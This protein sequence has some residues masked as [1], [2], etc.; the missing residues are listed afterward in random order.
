MIDP[1]LFEISLPAQPSDGPDD[2]LPPLPPPL[3]LLPEDKASK[4]R[5][6]TTDTA[7]I[8]PNPPKPSTTAPKSLAT[9]PKTPEMTSKAP[10]INSKS[11]QYSAASDRNTPHTWTTLEKCKHLELLYDQIYG[12]WINHPTSDSSFSNLNKHASIC[13]CKHGESQKTQSLACLGTTGTGDINPKEASSQPQGKLPPPHQV[14]IQA[15]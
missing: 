9:I 8:T 5:R 10:A 11:L 15:T 6:P 12:T 3:L 14:N 13:L 2:Q 1:T 7:E 4:N